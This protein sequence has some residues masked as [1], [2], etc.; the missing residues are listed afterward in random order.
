MMGTDFPHMNDICRAD[1]TDPELQRR[2]AK[3]IALHCFRNSMLQNLHEGVAPSSA[4][5][6]YADVIVHSPYGEIA[7]AQVSRINDEEMHRLMV[8]VVDRVY[9]FHLLFNEP[10]GQSLLRILAERDF[11]PQWQ[12]PKMAKNLW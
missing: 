1:L 7:W 3:C 2:L 9:R 5:G 11:K 6:D 10:D 4:T 8:D 12:E